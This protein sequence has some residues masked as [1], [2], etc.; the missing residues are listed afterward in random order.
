MAA[1]RDAVSADVAQ[2]KREFFARDD[3]RC[4]LTGKSLTWDEAHV[5]HVFPETFSALVERFASCID[6]D[7]DDV[8][9][10][11]VD[12]QA[13]R[14]IAQDWLADGFVSF[15]RVNAVLRVISA[16][17]NMKLSNKGGVL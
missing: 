12:G 8:E 4:T 10:V 14:K 5:D 1:F 15:H 6:L 17:A 2:F 3:H 11:S 13:G 9:T 7:L 16:E